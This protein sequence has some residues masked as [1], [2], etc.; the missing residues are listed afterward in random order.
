[1]DNLNK[2]K[3]CT[4]GTKMKILDTKLDDVKIIEP[5]VFKDHR[6]FFMESFNLKQFAELKLPFV[7]IQDNHS[8][9]LDKDVI[10]G[11]HYQLN[12]YSQTK[13]IRVITGA[14]YDVAVDIR[15]GSP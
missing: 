14:I 15:K 2:I 3:Y 11:L 5:K 1:M 13:L 6:G 9:S 4:G 12:P 7:F 8:L 10:R